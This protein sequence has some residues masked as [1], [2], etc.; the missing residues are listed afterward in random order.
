MAQGA[1]LVPKGF[2]QSRQFKG[3]QRFHVPFCEANPR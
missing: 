3:M 2:T 1:P